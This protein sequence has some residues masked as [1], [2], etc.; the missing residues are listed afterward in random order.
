LANS[1]DATAFAVINGNIRALSIYT[2]RTS[3][4]D[5]I[6]GVN[7]ISA[8]ADTVIAISL[9]AISAYAITLVASNLAAASTMANAR[10]GI[11]LVTQSTVTAHRQIVIFL[12]T[13]AIIALQVTLRAAT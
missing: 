10:R 5:I 1:S 4:I 9:I 7:A 3:T 6:A 13:F 2:S 12:I 11:I 8:R